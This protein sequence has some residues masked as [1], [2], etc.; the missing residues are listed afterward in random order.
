MAKIKGAIVVD[1]DRCKGCNLCVIACPTD[2]IAL[3]ET[4]NAK[5]YHPAYPVNHDACIACVNCALVCPDMCIT[6][7]K[8][9]TKKDV[10]STK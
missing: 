10:V 5:G 8:L 7:Y 6:V 2:V 9:D 4:V 1:T 3:K